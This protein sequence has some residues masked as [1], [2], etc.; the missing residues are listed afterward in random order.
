M[1]DG[2]YQ[3]LRLVIALSGALIAMFW[4][5]LVMWTYRDAQNRSSNFLV[6]VLAV[7][8]VASTFIA[9]WLVYLLLRPERT[10]A[11]AYKDRLEIRDLFVRSRESD[12]CP[13][14]GERIQPDYRLCPNC[15]LE[16]RRPCVSC[17]RSIRLAWNLCPY[18]GSSQ[19]QRRDEHQAPLTAPADDR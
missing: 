12:V 16:I 9:G 3:L 13:G 19:H 11:D 8:L 18:C 4:L 17:K 14:C 6:T 2:L 5:A 7:V 15:G 10:L 1:S